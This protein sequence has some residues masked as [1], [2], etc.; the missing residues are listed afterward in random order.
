[1]VSCKHNT[2]GRVAFRNFATRSIRNRTE[3]MFQV[4]SVS[5]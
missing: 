3:L 5:D 1:L 2:S 4:V